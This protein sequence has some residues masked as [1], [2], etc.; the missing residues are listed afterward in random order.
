[1][2]GAVYARSQFLMDKDTH[3]KAALNAPLN[4]FNIYPGLA[5]PRAAIDCTPNNDIIYGLV[6]LDL[7]QGQY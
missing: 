4:T 5:A 3:P 6:Q 2:V 1:M 7:R